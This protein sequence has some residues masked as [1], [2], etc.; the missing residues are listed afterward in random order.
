MGADGRCPFL[1]AERWCGIQTRL[2]EAAIPDTCAGYPRTSVTVGDMTDLAATLS[3]PEAARQALL[4]PDAMALVEADQWPSSRGEAA[5]V[6]SLAGRGPDDP[7]QRFHLMRAGVVHL[8]QRRDVS[9]AARLVAVG[10][11]LHQ[12][13]GMPLLPESA[14]YEVV[15]AHASRL[16]LVA[17]E[18]A[19]LRPA[20]E[21][22]LALLRSLGTE[23]IGLS[24]PAGDPFRHCVERLRSGL[25]LDREAAG[26]VPGALAREAA[27]SGAED[28]VSAAAVA[29]Y[30]AASRAYFAPYVAASPHVLENYLVNQVYTSAFPFG[31]GQC[32]RE[33]YALL[34]IWYALLRLYLV[35]VAAHEGRLTD[36]LV[37]EVVYRLHRALAH[38]DAYVRGVL[39]HLRQHD[40]LSLAYATAL[41]V[42]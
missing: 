17:A 1:T 40:A 14:C 36:A 6:V 16:S 41:A 28:R 7:W 29:A 21:L 35:G 9:L 8:L 38:D 27:G 4:V 20:R 13:D 15:Q 18:V 12:L 26:T 2:G 11:A 3:C 23:E 31:L 33:D 5:A 24:R 39:T 34:V 25:R 30:D 37:V 22:Q 19:S 42:D 10:Q 32:F